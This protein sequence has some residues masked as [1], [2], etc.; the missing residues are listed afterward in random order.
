[1]QQALSSC[2]GA[3]GAEAQAA[4]AW[5]FPLA[6]PFS[7]TSAGSS[8]RDLSPVR[9]GITDANT[10]AERVTLPQGQWVYGF[11]G[12]LGLEMPSLEFMLRESFPSSTSLP[13]HC[14]VGEELG[15]LRDT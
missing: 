14:F 15:Q 12:E 2:C 10:K 3:V 9:Q 8:P 13:W 5:P 6:R 4:W 7:H 11:T 1:M